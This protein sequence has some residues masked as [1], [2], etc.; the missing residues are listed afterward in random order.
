MFE[1][2]RNNYRIIFTDF[3]GRNFA[4]GVQYIWR[5]VQRRLPPIAQLPLPQ[6]LENEDEGDGEVEGDGEEQRFNG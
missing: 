2:Q 3:D 6:P 4:P 5:S 1:S